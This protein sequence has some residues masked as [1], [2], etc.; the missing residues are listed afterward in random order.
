LLDLNY[1][2]PLVEKLPSEVMDEVLAKLE[3]L[4]T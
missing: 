3:A 1:N 4:L 2:P